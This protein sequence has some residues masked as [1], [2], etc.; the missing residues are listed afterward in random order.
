MTERRIRRVFRLNDEIVSVLDSLVEITTLPH[1]PSQVPRFTTNAR[2]GSLFVFHCPS[3]AGVGRVFGVARC[4]HG[5]A[6]H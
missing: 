4:V 3:A 5:A 1:Q 6:K 2:D